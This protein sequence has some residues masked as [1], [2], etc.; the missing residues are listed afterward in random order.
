[1]L[2]PAVVLGSY[3]TDCDIFPPPDDP[4]GKECRQKSKWTKRAVGFA[5]Q[6]VFKGLLCCI[7]N[8]H[9]DFLKAIC[10]HCFVPTSADKDEWLAGL[11]CECLCSYGAMQGF[12]CIQCV[13]TYPECN[14]VAV[15]RSV[16]V[17][18]ENKDYLKLCGGI[19]SEYRQVNLLDCDAGDDPATYLAMMK[20]FFFARSNSPTICK[21]RDALNA[22]VGVDFQ[23]IY[24]ADGELGVFADLTPEQLI[25]FEIA[26]GWYVSD[27]E[28]C[29][30]LEA[31]NVR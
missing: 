24:S 9:D 4:C 21:I 25:L 5:D 2:K 12:P 20:A 10:S 18:G 13:V 1:M 6:G 30:L 23:V 15:G 28:I 22:A 17:C 31:P 11:S 29:L 26:R 16:S 27:V 19:C 3:S 8:L 14:R 7:L